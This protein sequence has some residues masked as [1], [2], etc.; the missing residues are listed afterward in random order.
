LGHAERRALCSPPE[1]SAR[2]RPLPDAPAPSPQ[3]VDPSAAER[4]ASLAGSAPVK[5]LG[6]RA[7][8]DLLAALSDELPLLGDPQVGAC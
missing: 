3:D 6:A 4:R 5:P 1:L 8:G 2:P 7:T